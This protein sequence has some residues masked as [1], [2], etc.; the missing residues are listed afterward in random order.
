MS[1]SK[2]KG[3]K[4]ALWGFT[5][6]VLIILTPFSVS[7]LIGE[8]MTDYFEDYNLG[9]LLNQGYWLDGSTNFDVVDSNPYSGLQS[10][11]CLNCGGLEIIKYIS[12]EKQSVGFISFAVYL[13]TLA[14]D[15][16]YVPLVNLW[17]C[18]EAEPETC[19][20]LGAIEV[21]RVNGVYGFGIL[22]GVGYTELESNLETDAWH[23]IGILF[24]ELGWRFSAKIDD[25]FI[26]DWFDFV[27]ETQKGLIDGIYRVGVYVQ[28]ASSSLLYLDDFSGPCRL[29][30]CSYCENRE[31]CSEAGCIW[32]DDPLYYVLWGL[33]GLC[34]EPYEEDEEVCGSFLK[35]RFCETQETC[36]AELNC[37]WA[38][39][40]EGP[41]CYIYAFT[42]PP[43][44]VDWEAPDLENCGPLSGV[45]K[46]L[47]EIK[48]FIA[49]IFMPTQI[50][51][52]ELFNTIQN[53]KIKFPFNYV[54]AMNDFF[55][56]IRDSL[57]EEKGIPITILE[58]ESSVDFSFWEKTTT[59]GGESET[60]GNVIKDFTSMIILIGWFVWLISFIK[61]FF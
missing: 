6:G 28:T 44:Q 9:D 61:R 51:I 40:G 45:E 27:S 59:I 29:G 3:L 31:T 17:G 32:F 60:L 41:K 10:I 12:P 54:M 21:R 53:F 42:M 20:S 35:C 15:G 39:K 37:E 43:T 56:D 49:G 23:I 2:R 8:Y 48:N 25:N 34:V 7:A 47:C 18:Y 46:W 50:K 52:D 19:I 13:P 16:T 55:I 38:D 11:Y 4:M 58:Q 30:T 22:S 36:E 24:D 5:L 33:P 14:G 57:D 1:T 26:S